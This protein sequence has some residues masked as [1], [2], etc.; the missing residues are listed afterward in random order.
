VLRRT[1]EDFEHQKWDCDLKK[2]GIPL[3]TAQQVVVV[4]SV[5]IVKTTI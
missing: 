4:G 3:L 2:N 1:F 5:T